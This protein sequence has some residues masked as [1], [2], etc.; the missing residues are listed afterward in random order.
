MFLAPEPPS[1]LPT[2]R[3]LAP[4]IARPDRLTG[5]RLTILQILFGS[6]VVIGVLGAIA[7]LTTGYEIYEDGSNLLVKT[8]PAGS[9]STVFWCLAGAALAALGISRPTRRNA[10]VIGWMFVLLIVVGSLAVLSI[11]GLINLDDFSFSQHTVE[12]GSVAMLQFAIGAMVFAG[13][14]LLVAQWRLFRY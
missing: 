14:V 11:D 6:L 12:T 9:G 7:S 10:K 2:A 8:R 1:Y 13:P 5:E 4:A 3:V